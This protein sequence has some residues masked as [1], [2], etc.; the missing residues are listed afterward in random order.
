[1][2]FPLLEGKTL[3]YEM[4]AWNKLCSCSIIKGVIDKSIMIEF[5]DRWYNGLNTVFD[6]NADTL[7]LIK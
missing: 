7:N 5:S 3:N 4:L 1:M 2:V 6:L